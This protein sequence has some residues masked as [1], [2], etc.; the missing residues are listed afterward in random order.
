MVVT[1]ANRSVFTAKITMTSSPLFF[2][3]NLNH[4]DLI[5]CSHIRLIDTPGYMTSRNRASRAFND[6]IFNYIQDRFNILL[7]RQSVID[8]RHRYLQEGVDVDVTDGDDVI[9]SRAADVIDRVQHQG[10]GLLRLLDEEETEEAEA[11]VSRILRNNTE[12]S[13]DVYDVIT[14]SQLL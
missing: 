5:T 6:V 2:N 9:V 4:K 14:H 13:R 8:A 1:I 7:H 10:K 11:L 12:G 3:R